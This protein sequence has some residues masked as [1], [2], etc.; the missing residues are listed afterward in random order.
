[1]RRHGSTRDRYEAWRTRRGLVTAGPTAGPAAQPYIAFMKTKT[2]IPMA[3]PANVAST[4]ITKDFATITRPR[5]TQPVPHVTGSMP[6][7]DRHATPTGTPYFPGRS[8]I[9]LH[10]MNA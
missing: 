9:I 2:P 1:M 5:S 6:S 7:P 8:E 3:G 4:S 10:R